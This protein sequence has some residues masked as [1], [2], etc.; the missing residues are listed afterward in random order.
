MDIDSLS[1]VS[2]QNE[3]KKALLNKQDVEYW[4]INESMHSEEACQLIRISEVKKLTTLS[5]ST[6]ALWVAQGRFPTPFS[7]S[8]TIKV[9][10][11]SDIAQW[12]KERSNDQ[13]PK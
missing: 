4:S 12:I 3:V 5:K 2:L 1:I 9:W 7:L 10:R 13:S 6:I 8:P 11:L